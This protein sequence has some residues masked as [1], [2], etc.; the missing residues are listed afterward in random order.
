[1]PGNHSSLPA[2]A[3]ANLTSL[4]P[5]NPAL[6]LIYVFALCLNFFYCGSLI[7]I[8]VFDFDLSSV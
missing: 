8:L 1:M 3:P 2:L 4:M 7:L 6:C 5:C